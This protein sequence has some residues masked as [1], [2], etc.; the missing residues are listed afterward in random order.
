[1]WEKFLQALA[2]EFVKKEDPSSINQG[3]M[4]LGA[5]IC[6]PKSPSCF[7]CPIKKKCVARQEDLM[8]ELP[9]KKKKKDNEIW[10]WEA[11]LFEQDQKLALLTSLL[12]SMV[13]LSSEKTS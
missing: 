4:E 8:E 2:D 9:L 12:N 11:Q 13:F 6:T 10:V 3:L 1:M 5:T 7:L